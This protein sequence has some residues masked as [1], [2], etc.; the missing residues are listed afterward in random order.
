MIIYEWVIFNPINQVCSQILDCQNN[1]ID[2]LNYKL[3]IQIMAVV[4]ITLNL[5]ILT[6]LNQ[7]LIDIEFCDKYILFRKRSVSQLIQNVLKTMLVYLEGTQKYVISNV[8]GIVLI[9]DYLLNRPYR[10]MVSM[11]YLLLVLNFQTISVLYSSVQ[12]LKYYNILILVIM[13]QPF[14]YLL[15]K[16]FYQNYN[17]GLLCKKFSSLVDENNGEI[18]KQMELLYEMGLKIDID[19]YFRFQLVCYLKS[20]ILSDEMFIE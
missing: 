11:F 5:A 13:V 18:N 15:A 16:M 9:S 17:Y 3:M 10:T 7:I 2:D 12:V 20:N 8:L 19:Q 1:C 14:L 4:Q 6:I